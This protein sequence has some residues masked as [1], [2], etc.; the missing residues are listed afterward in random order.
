MSHLGLNPQTSA[1]T[2]GTNASAHY[3]DGL[4]SLHGSDG[5]I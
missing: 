5:D 4:I 1:N 2:S 3:T